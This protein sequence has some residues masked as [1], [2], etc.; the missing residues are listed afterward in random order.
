M[1]FAIASDRYFLKIVHV[2]HSRFDDAQ[3]Q[4]AT[5]PATGKI[6]TNPHKTAHACQDKPYMSGKT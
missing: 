4:N 3:S 5:A 1:G 6:R 2:R